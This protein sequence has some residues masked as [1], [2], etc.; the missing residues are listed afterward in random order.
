MIRTKKGIA[1]KRI[2]ASPSENSGAEIME[3]WFV[4]LVMVLEL[5]L[6]V[7]EVVVWVGV[8]LRGV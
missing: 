4:V 1:S 7:L 3:V 2:D 6:V 8:V 5:V